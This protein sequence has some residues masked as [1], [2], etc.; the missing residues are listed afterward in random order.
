MFNKAYDLLFGMEGAYDSDPDDPGG[1]TFCGI[2]RNFHKDWEG[3]ITIDNFKRVL[4]K[5]DNTKVKQLL[6][7]NTLINQ[8]KAFYK[9]ENWDKFE[10]DLLPYSLAVE[11]FEQSVNLGVPR[12]SKF[13]QMVLNGLN[14]NGCFGQDID[15]DGRFGPVSKNRLKTAIEKGCAK[16]IQFGINCLQGSHYINNSIG[17]KT[18]RKYLKGWLNQRTEA[19]YKEK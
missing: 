5:I 7:D 18:K 8:V 11:I 19:L 14:N 9:K 3:W 2:A 6:K 16:S 12:T 13:I 17:D 10:C 15:T 1:E 4:G